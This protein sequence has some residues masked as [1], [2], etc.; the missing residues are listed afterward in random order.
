VVAATEGFAT[1]SLTDFGMLQGDG[2]MTETAKRVAERPAM[3]GCMTAGMAQAQKL[4]A[5]VCWVKD[6]QRWQQRKS[7]QPPK[8]HFLAAAQVENL[9]KW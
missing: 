3:Q 2:D 9:P 4:Q 8:Q 6:Q 7:K 5:L 1:L